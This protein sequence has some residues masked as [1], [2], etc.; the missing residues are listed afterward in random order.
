MDTYRVPSPT[1]RFQFNK[2]A[3]VGL[4]IRVLTLRILVCLLLLVHVETH[5]QVCWDVWTT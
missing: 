3:S 1:L 5:L 4:I 2:R